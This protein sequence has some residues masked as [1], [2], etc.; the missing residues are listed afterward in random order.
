MKGMYRTAPFLFLALAAFAQ[1]DAPSAGN[2]PAE[3]DKA[4]RA[5]VTE[6]YTLI[7]NEEY[8]KAESYIADD[9]KDY[10]YDGQKPVAHTFELIE[11]RYSDNFTHAVAYT[12]CS[13]PLVMAGFPPAELVLKIPTLWRLENGNW[14]LYEDP[15]KR[16]NPGGIQAK[17]SAALQA[18]A[19]AALAG[20]PAI[21]KEVPK[22]G[23][24]VAPPAFAMAKLEADKTQ[25]DLEP[26][27]T[28]HVTFTNGSPGVMELE[29]GYHLTGIETKLDRSTVGAGEKAILTFQAGK[30]PKP[31][32]FFVKVNPTGEVFD[33]RVGIKK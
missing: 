26:G 7:H 23:A 2:P 32:V 13:Q 5:R 25:F 3:V 29:L 27:G 22:D 14:Y 16:K 28:E 8:R 4:L 9:T 12:K 17:V 33:I 6:F 20:P 15:E 30:E 10:Y 19:S 1:T 31:G 21:L 11:L 24:P 18:G